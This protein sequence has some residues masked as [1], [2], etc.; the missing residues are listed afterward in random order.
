MAKRSHIIVPIIIFVIFIISYIILSANSYGMFNFRFLMKN[1]TQVEIKEDFEDEYIEID[2]ENEEGKKVV[3]FT[4]LQK[5][6]LYLYKY[7]NTTN[8]KNITNYLYFNSKM[9][10]MKDEI[11]DDTVIISIYNDSGFAFS[12]P[13]KTYIINP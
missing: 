1:S 13:I 12:T 9:K 5:N 3:Y 11:K 8:P 2:I 7:Q 4:R 10:P 6:Y